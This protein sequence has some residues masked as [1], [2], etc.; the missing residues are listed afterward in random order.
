MREGVFP[1]MGAREPN[2]VA[3]GETS[4]VPVTRPRSAPQILANSPFI[5]PLIQIKREPGR[6]SSNRH[7]NHKTRGERWRQQPANS[8]KHKNRTGI[9]ALSTASS[10][11]C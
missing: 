9:C 4:G 6:T 11:A 10:A 7:G 5:A 1:G 3:T 2:A 8:N